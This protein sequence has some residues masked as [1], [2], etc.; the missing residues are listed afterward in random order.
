MFLL[1][2]L[3]LYLTTKSNLRRPQTKLFISVLYLNPLQNGL[4]TH[5]YPSEYYS[6]VRYAQVASYYFLTSR[7]LF[8]LNHL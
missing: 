3:A 4:K 2:F 6:A 7:K 1:F 5:D 8:R